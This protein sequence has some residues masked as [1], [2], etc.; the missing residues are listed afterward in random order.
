VTFDLT[1]WRHDRFEALSQGSLD[2][3]LDADGVKVPSPLQRAHLHQ[4]AFV[5]VVSAK[6]FKGRRLT[7]KQYVEGSH[8]SVNTLAGSQT[9]PDDRL[10][11]SA[12]NGV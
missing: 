9:L 3:V 5:W 10:A 4:E 12:I 6:S 7:L 2:L 1:A 8:I 11:A